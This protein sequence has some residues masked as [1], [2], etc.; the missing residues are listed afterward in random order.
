[1]ATHAGD[2]LH[3][4]VIGAHVSDS[5]EREGCGASGC[6]QRGGASN[7]AR[8]LAG[9]HT[10]VPAAPAVSSGGDAIR[11]DPPGG[12]QEGVLQG[13]QGL[14]QG[15]APGAATPVSA[16]A[17]VGLGF[18]YALGAGVVT[19]LLDSQRGSNS[20]KRGSG[21]RNKNPG[22]P[23]GQGAVSGGPDS[24]SGAGGNSFSC[25]PP[26]LACPGPI[27][28]C[29][30]ALAASQ[31]RAEGIPPPPVFGTQSMSPALAGASQPQGG[32]GADGH[33]LEDRSQRA[34]GSRAADLQPPPRSPPAVSADPGGHAMVR[35]ERPE[36]PEQQSRPSL[37]QPTR[38]GSGT[39]APTSGSGAGQPG[40]P[41]GSDGSAGAGAAR[42]AGPPRGA[43]KSSGRDMAGSIKI[44]GPPR[45]Q[46]S[47]AQRAT[48]GV[49][50]SALVG[51]A[52]RAGV[53][54]HPDPVA[55]PVHTP[56]EGEAAAA[57]QLL[58]QPAAGGIT[59]PGGKADDGAAAVAETRLPE[60]GEAAGS[61]REAKRLRLADEAEAGDGSQR[62][63]C[64]SQ[65]LAGASGGGSGGGNSQADVS[66]GV[67]PV[68]SQE[69]AG[70]G[71]EGLLRLSLELSS[72][73][74]QMCGQRETPRV[75]MPGA[76]CFG[77]FQAL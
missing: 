58:V 3:S 16:G 69:K 61:A 70:E 42:A 67:W 12:M 19:V 53:H 24:G 20:P 51:I 43:G 41:R 50:V 74:E 4:G 27:P 18:G 46:A 63:Q 35:S 23:G 65:G 5:L 28:C 68:Q 2:I 39:G 30:E 34:P 33:P 54:A 66:V 47:A 25:G 52:G 10:C 9:E 36:R 21:E 6:C 11:G 62:S 64:Q 37:S 55:D 17:A 77:F 13:L 56:P 59:R 14:S 31:P 73:E 32:Q 45:R 26:G 49:A 29:D 44:G 7:Q 40:G 15:A 8:G 22:D 1:M 60:D 48:W 38:G 75:P 76:N 72:S 71:G 57:A